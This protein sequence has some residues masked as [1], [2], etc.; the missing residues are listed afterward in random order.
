M[1]RLK[2]AGQVLAVGLVASM[3]GLLAWKVTH[4]DG[5][6]PAAAFERGER[7]VA[8]GF[9]LDRMDEDGE[10]SL[11]SLRGRVVVLNFWASWCDPCRK[12]MPRLEQAWQRYRERGVTFVGVNTTD[13]TG[14]AERFLRRYRVTF[15]VVRDGNG[16][17]LA[18]YGGLPIPWTY[19]VGRDGRIVGYIRGEVTEDALEDGLEQALAA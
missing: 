4:D 2:L 11:S 1:R 7:P 14:D 13:F 12:E 8:R 3:L 18:R 9:T 6:N 17:V 5:G 15:P 16:R 19:F 10:L